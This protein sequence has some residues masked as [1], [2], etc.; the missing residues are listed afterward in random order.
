[1][2][3]PKEDAQRELILVSG[4]GDSTARK[5][6]DAGVTSIQA[7]AAIEPDEMVPKTGLHAGTL[8]RLRDSAALHLASPPAEP[9]GEE[10]ALAEEALEPGTPAGDEE[11]AKAK[12]KDKKLKKKGKGKKAKKGKKGGKKK[13]KKDKKKKK[14]GKK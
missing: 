14:K 1:M 9:E 4:V 8:V 7:L 3:K 11:P 6:V 13:A 5:L 10:P 12:K 2:K